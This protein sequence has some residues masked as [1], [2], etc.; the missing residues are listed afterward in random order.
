MVIRFGGSASPMG[1]RGL[2][3]F[4]AFAHCLVRQA[5]NHEAGEAGRNLRLHFY[6]TYFEAQ[7]GNGIYKSEQLH[8]P[9]LEFDKV[10]DG[11]YI[12]VEGCGPDARCIPL[13]SIYLDSSQTIA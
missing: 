3:P 5:H 4:A 10:M 1:K 12:V 13:C 6:I 8:A 9:I 11:F 7:I 2:N